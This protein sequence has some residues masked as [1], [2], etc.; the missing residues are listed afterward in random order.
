MKIK[1]NFI[2]LS[3]I[4]FLVILLIF[5]HQINKQSSASKKNE[6][7]NILQQ[8][9]TRNNQLVKIQKKLF[10]NRKNLNDIINKEEINFKSVFKDKKLNGLNNYSYSKYSTDDILFSGNRGAIGTAFIDFYDNDKNLLIATY[11]G[12]FAYTNLNNLEQFKKINS[13]INS[14]INYERFYFHEHYGI[15]DIHINNEKLYVSYIGKRKDNCY[16]LKII[17]TKL[18]EIFLNF[19]L[20]YQTSNCVD[21]NNNHGF[22]AHQGAGGRIVNLDN[23][24]LLFTTGD[25]RNR[26]LSQNIKSDFGKI[27]KINI[28]NKKSEVVSLGHRNPQ[29]LYYSKKFDFILSTEHGPKGGDEINI[30][31]G[32][33]SKVKNFGWPISSYGEHYKKNYSEKILSE[34]PLNKSH[35]KFDFE[36][37]IKYFDPSIGISQTI[38]LNEADTEFLIGAMG[39]EIADQDLGIHYIKLN[40]KRDKVID[41]DY[42]LLNDRVRDMVVSKDKKIIIIFLESTSSISILRKKG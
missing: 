19:E 15:K 10:Q 31:N 39:N 25:F 27:L 2:Y 7:S 40:K 30:N 26:P 9:K 24:N 38:S 36:E 32:P 11:D 1:S 18:N 6:I 4:I 42:F 34:A 41:H 17:S 8:L 5:G 21:E 13:N 35:K 37:P 16:D 3:I 29:G 33:F 20:F 14:L 28:Q 12:I 23:A 22:W